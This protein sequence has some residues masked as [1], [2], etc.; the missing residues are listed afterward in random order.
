MHLFQRSKVP[1][2]RWLE[3]TASPWEGRPVRYQIAQRH[4]FNVRGPVIRPVED[5]KRGQAP[6]AHEQ[7][8]TSPV[9]HTLKLVSGVP[10]FETGRPHSG[11][12]SRHVEV[13]EDPDAGILALRD[14]G[15]LELRPK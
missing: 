6:V 11:S 4:K 13:R 8:D 14:H 7:D 5:L 2:G 1:R 10:E 9:L 12:I 15:V 3:V